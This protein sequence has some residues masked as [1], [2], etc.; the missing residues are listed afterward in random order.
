MAPK[1]E[2]GLNESDCEAML[3]TLDGWAFAVQGKAWTVE[4]YG[5]WEADG[6]RWIQLAL[7]GER[8]HRLTLRIQ[9]RADIAEAMSRL[10]SWIAAPAERDD[11]LNVS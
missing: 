2:A 8:S 3:A 9:S 1:P 10:A 4:P 11:V 5:A 7:H 6:F